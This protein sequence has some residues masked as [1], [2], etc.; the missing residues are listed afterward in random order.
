MT[1]KDSL[2]KKR[3]KFVK[4]DRRKTGKSVCKKN[5]GTM[6][7]NQGMN[8]KQKQPVPAKICEDRPR[9]NGTLTGP[10]CGLQQVAS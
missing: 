6:S 4:K 3:F 5:R 8:M 1:S 10:D 7:Q 2:A 9:Q